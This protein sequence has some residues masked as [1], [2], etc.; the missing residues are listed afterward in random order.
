[1]EK[2]SPIGSEEAGGFDRPK[3]IRTFYDIMFRNNN[4]D[5]GEI[6]GW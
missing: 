1:M 6:N 3:V 4:K 2:V 5:I